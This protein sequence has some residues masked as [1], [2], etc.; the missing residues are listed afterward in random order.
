MLSSLFSNILIL[1]K[2]MINMI[3]GKLICS[4]GG[5]VSLCGNPPGRGMYVVTE[6]VVKLN[7]FLVVKK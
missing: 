3:N 4:S 1:V 5:K 2:L 7:L 6:L